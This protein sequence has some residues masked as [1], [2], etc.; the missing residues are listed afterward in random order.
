[1]LEAYGRRLRAPPPW[2]SRRQEARPQLRLHYF[3]SR[4]PERDNRPWLG[5]VLDSGRSHVT[6]PGERGN[7]FL[8]GT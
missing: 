3:T 1:M 2:S 7:D 6:V 8:V 5:H 4:M